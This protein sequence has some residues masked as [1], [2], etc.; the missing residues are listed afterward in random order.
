[1]IRYILF[2]N[3]FIIANCYKFSV[4][5]LENK[6]A[7]VYECDIER[8]NTK[9]LLELFN[10]Y[11]LLIFRNNINSNNINPKKFID[12][13]TIFDPNAD[14]EA[15]NNPDLYPEQLLQ[16]F[17][18][19]PDCKHVAPIGNFNRK[20]YVWNAD[21]LGHKSKK[22]NKITGFHIFEQ[23]LIGGNTDFISGETIYD[24]LPD[25]YK[26]KIKNVKVVV[27]RK[28]F[29]FGNKEMD[30]SGSY[31]IQDS[32]IKFPEDNIILP[33]FF[34][35]EEKKGSIL[36]LPS[37]IENIVGI[38]DRE[39]NKLMKHFMINHVLPYRISIQWKKGD[40]CVLN[41]KKYIHS[42]T[43]AINFIEK[44]ERLLFQAFVPTK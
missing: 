36:L 8:P 16:P 18:Q 44:N 23:P 11:P 41:N 40:I 4:H 37:F 19:F 21:M 27:N 38:S 30:Y 35:T 17:D 34:P 5:P 15:I 2:F 26:D 9:I 1:M 33:I 14:I 3:I 7:F 12:F 42:D 25:I 20:N 39:S 28:N 31:K 29:Y 43:P 10:D 24:N 22:L 32:N 6:C 13:L